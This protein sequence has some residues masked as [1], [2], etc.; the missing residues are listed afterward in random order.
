MFVIYTYV[1]MH[2][3]V[4]IYI[5]IYIYIKINI[6]IYVCVCV[7]IYMYIICMYIY[8]YIIMYIYICIYAEYIQ[9]HQGIKNENQRPQKIQEKNPRKKESVKHIAH[10]RVAKTHRMPYLYRSLFAKEPHN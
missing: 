9:R 6:H 5:Y 1:N 3:Y 7:Y 10:Y 8:S 4:Y 2:M